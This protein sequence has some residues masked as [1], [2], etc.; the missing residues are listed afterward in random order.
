MCFNF[1][2]SN[3]KFLVFCSIVILK[4]LLSN[5]KQTMA[6]KGKN[7]CSQTFSENTLKT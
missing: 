2:R 1:Y 7:D 6:H 5:V 3:P 4:I